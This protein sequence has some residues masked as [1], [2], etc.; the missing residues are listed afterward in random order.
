MTISAWAVRLSG[1]ESEDRGR[2]RAT[3]RWEAERV[4]VGCEAKERAE[5]QR[6]MAPA[7][8]PEAPVPRQRNGAQ[9]LLAQLL[10]AAQEETRQGATQCLG[11]A[12]LELGH[13]PGRSTSNVPFAPWRPGR[14]SVRR[15]GGAV[16]V[17]RASQRH[18]IICGAC[19]SVFAMPSRQ[20]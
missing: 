7:R 6:Q 4:D 20:R 3:S 9:V 19:R 1:S 10:E 13:G 18:R 2:G 12:Q 14:A 5:K 15:S 17:A 8:E 16:N 11:L